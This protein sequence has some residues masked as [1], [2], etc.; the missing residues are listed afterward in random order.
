LRRRQISYIDCMDRQALPRVVSKRR[1]G[2]EGAC[3]ASLTR[4][5]LDVRQSLSNSSPFAMYR[6][7]RRVTS[8]WQCLV[9]EFSLR[10][11]G[12]WSSELIDNGVQHYDCT[13]KSQWCSIVAVHGLDGDRE[14]SWTDR[15]S[16][17]CW[18]SHPKFLPSMIPN[19]RVIVF[20]YIVN[21]VSNTLS[22]GT[23]EDHSKSLIADLSRLRATTKV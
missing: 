5:F 7:I 3:D 1:A 9:L 4:V 19:A 17:I 23:I 2:Q 16:G 11:Y 10:V 20:G 6:L 13:T 12:Q 15:S 18:L 8:I 22:I 21:T 14:E